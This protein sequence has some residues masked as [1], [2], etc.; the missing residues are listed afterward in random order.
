MVLGDILTGIATTIVATF[1]KVV[2]W[3]MNVAPRPIKIFV[4]MMLLLT[5]GNLISSVL[6]ST[7]FVCTSTNQLRRVTLWDG[8]RL[9]FTRIV[10]PLTDEE[11]I[12]SSQAYTPESVT[13][14]VACVNRSPK[15]FFY[16][17]NILSYPLW[18]LLLLLIYAIPL[19]I[20]W[21]KAMGVI[22]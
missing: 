4:F 13:F 11:I 1:H 7:S 17:I 3:F 21:Y 2:D 8:V 12:S 16:N 14:R 9:F 10:T 5:L 19:V 22:H 15:P 20:K 18:L 6:L